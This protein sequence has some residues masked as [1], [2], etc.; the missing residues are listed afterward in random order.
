M[1]YLCIMHRN[2]PITHTPAHYVRLALLRSGPVTHRACPTGGTLRARPY[3]DAVLR[4][5]ALKVYSSFLHG[6]AYISPFPLYP[7][8]AS[9]CCLFTRSSFS[10]D[11]QKCDA[12]SVLSPSQ[13]TLHALRPNTM[14][15]AALH[16]AFRSSTTFLTARHI[17]AAYSFNAPRTASRRM[18][19]GSTTL[20]AVTPPAKKQARRR[21]IAPLRR[22]SAY[23]L[24]LTQLPCRA[25]SAQALRKHGIATAPIDAPL[26]SASSGRLRRADRLRRTARLAS[27]QGPVP[28]RGMRAYR[29]FAACYAVPPDP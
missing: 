29:R 21:A 7:L 17:K 8:R 2:Q 24:T 13:S 1:I 18:L 27:S 15:N 12:G 14:R 20:R 16:V 11:A 9:S 25:S 3:A 23:G 26:H 4:R 10:G 28:L 5:L 22:C 19:R 6:V